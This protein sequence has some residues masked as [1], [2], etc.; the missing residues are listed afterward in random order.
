[1]A[2][3]YLLALAATRRTPGVAGVVALLLGAL[4]PTLSNEGMKEVDVGINHFWSHS[5]LVPAALGVGAL[6]LMRVQQRHLGAI[7]GFFT[8]GLVSHLVADFVTDFALLYLSHRVDDI[9]GSW[10]YPWRPIIVREPILLPGF[11]ILWWQLAVEIPLVAWSLWHW[12]S[13]S[14]SHSIPMPL[15]LVIALGVAAALG[16]F[17]GVFQVRRGY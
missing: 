1:M 13:R 4:F 6:G 15:V 14:R 5:P 7:L 10:L 16:I 2:F 12:I 17:V 8:L 3:A 9:G 11:R